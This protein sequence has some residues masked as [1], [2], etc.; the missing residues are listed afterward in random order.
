[1]TREKER[2]DREKKE[3]AQRKREKRGKEK[4]K[5]GQFVFFLFTR[6][7]RARIFFLRPLAFVPSASAISSREVDFRRGAL[8]YSF[9]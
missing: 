3:K 7:K 6:L 9:M 1:M 5:R 4:R 8:L 2:R